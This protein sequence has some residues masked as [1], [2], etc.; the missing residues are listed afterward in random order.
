MDPAILK[1]SIPGADSCEETSHGKFDVELSVDIGIIRGK[2]R[3]IVEAIDLIPPDSQRLIMNGEG[4]GGWIKGEGALTFRDADG[5]TEINVDG[6]ALPGGV[7]ARVGQRMIGNAAKTL[8]GQFF[9]NL[10]REVTR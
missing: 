6:E 3:G 2:F 5:G 7:L 1:A 10:N 8:M 9:K 4:P